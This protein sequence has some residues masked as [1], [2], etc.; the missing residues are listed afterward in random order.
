VSTITALPAAS[1]ANT[2]DVIPADQ[3]NND[4]SIT[5]RKVSIAQIGAVI[6]GGGGG[7]VSSVVGQTGAVTAAQIS[8]AVAGSGLSVSNGQLSVNFPAPPVTSVAGSTGAVTVTE[9]A[10]A[11]AGTGLTVDGVTGKLDASGGGAVSSVVGQTGAVTAAQIT[12]AT[13]GLIATAIAG[14]GLTVSGGQL[15]V[16]GGSGG[17]T[18]VVGQ[19]GAVTATEISTAIAGSGLSVSNGQLAVSFPAPPVT[20][21]AGSTGAVTVTELATALAGTG[22]TVDG[23]TGKLDAS[24]A[25][26]SPLI[27]Q[28][29]QN[30]ITS[31]ATN[32]L[33]YGVSAPTGTTGQETAI[34]T[35]ITNALAA[36]TASGATGVK[37][38]WD[39]AVALGGTI[40]LSSNMT[41]ECPHYGCGAIMRAQASGASVPILAVNGSQL[42]MGGGAYTGAYIANTQNTFGE[43]NPA[44][45]G[46]SN[47]Q[48]Y[49]IFNPAFVN[50]NNITILGG[51]W[52]GNAPQQGGFRATGN[53]SN[54]IPNTTNNVGWAHGLDFRGV[55]GLQLIRPRVFLALQFGIYCVNCAN[56]LIIEPDVDQANTENYDN[57]AIHFN[58]PCQHVRVINPRVHC[59]DDCIA[60]N[61]D[62]ANF[63]TANFHNM[64]SGV[65]W[66]CGGPITDVLV[67]KPVVW[68]GRVNATTNPTN[69]SWGGICFRSTVN[70]IDDV[71]VRGYSGTTANLAIWAP[72]YAPGGTSD[73]LVPGPGNIGRVLL[74]NTTIDMTSLTNAPAVI[75]WGL[76]T[77]SLTIRNRNRL[78]AAGPVP[79]IFVAP[80][81]T[82][83]QMLV[84]GYSSYQPVGATNNAEAALTICGT[85]GSL[86]MSGIIGRDSSITTGTMPALYMPTFTPTGA[87]NGG[88]PNSGAGTIGTAK[89]D[90]DAE[91]ISNVVNVAVA[92]ASIT[93]LYL[94]GFHRNAGGG[95][96]LANSGSV[97]SYIVGSGV[98][99]LTYNSGSVASYTGNA[100]L[101]INAYIEGGTVTVQTPAMAVAG[102]PL[103]VQGSYAGPTPSGGTVTVT[104]DASTALTGFTAA[105]GWWNA[106]ATAPAAEVSAATASVTLNT[107]STA[108]SASDFTISATGATVLARA[109]FIP[110]TTG[111]ATTLG[112]YT[113]S[114][115][116]DV[117]N[118]WSVTTTGNSTTV[119]QPI[120][121]A[122]GGG[123]T[124]GPLPYGAYFHNETNIGVMLPTS[125]WKIQITDFVCI[126]GATCKPIIALQVYSDATQANCFQVTLNYVSATS[127]TYVFGNVSSGVT[128]V[129][130][131]ATLTGL[132]FNPFVIKGTWTMVNDGTNV[133]VY[134]NSTL[135]CSVAS[136]LISTT[137]TGGTTYTYAGWT[138]LSNVA[139][140]TC[141]Y[142]LG[143]F[144]VT[145]P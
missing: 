111:F 54:P 123:L 24:G 86:L 23:S 137:L 62:D 145:A 97:S 87:Q 29:S 143:T 20:S 59:A 122:T 74:D 99:P 107:G 8:T 48:F 114:S 47:P 110:G 55:N 56:V 1:A 41:I 64:P 61:A 65:M 96:P 91:G 31:D 132:S 115:N 90:L 50:A 66:A 78:N 16:T 34:Q 5:T 124:Q 113:G 33:E 35:L 101:N 75:A 18:S 138:A 130:G 72:Q 98:Y 68:A 129:I 79:D 105:S 94:S 102:S 103:Y 95:S 135:V 134:F 13:S 43:F 89:I 93:N 141:T 117:N 82:I 120:I 2:T 51:T 83:N 4:G 71:V 22:L 108:T 139:G 142:A 15:N 126:G 46:Q 28:L 131:T 119:I 144:S 88:F 30:G 45:S 140:Q 44:F 52:N 32:G 27:L 39:V 70:L 81:V 104:G 100:P 92:N 17:V 60:L 116:G 53:T 11:L 37:V 58:G 36:A 128:S 57:D 125:G 3:I 67:D 112:A 73:M 19:T 133:K 9:L 109:S 85:V 6:G 38:I 136:N 49:R 121:A 69:G 76:N 26:A 127:L 25:G 12:S 21:V 84:D 63:N 14:T 80:G 77:Q 42:N 10:T 106:V 118:A 7:A 40:Y